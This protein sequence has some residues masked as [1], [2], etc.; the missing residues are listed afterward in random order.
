MASRDVGKVMVDIEARLDN[1]ERGMKKAEGTVKKSVDKMDKEAEKFGSGFSKS[2]DRIIKAFGILGAVEGGL[3]LATAATNLWDAALGDAA[4][5]A[6]K[7]QKALDA[8]YESITQLPFG[9]GPAVQ[10]FDALLRKVTGIGAEIDRLNSI[11]SGLDSINAVSQAAFEQRK[12]LLEQEKTL[13][14]T[15]PLERI[16]AEA[17]AQ[18]RQIEIE[19]EATLK[20]LR[21]TGQDPRTAENSL[22]QRREIQFRLIEAEKERRLREVIE[23]DL[24]ELG[25]ERIRRQE[26]AREAS[27]ELLIKELEAEGK[28]LDA[29]LEQIKQ[30]Y[31]KR[32]SLAKGAEE[33]YLLERLRA[34][35][36]AEAKKQTIITDAA[37]ETGGGAAFESFQTAIGALRSP[38]ITE[39]GRYQQQ[40]ADNTEQIK[41]NTK[42]SASLLE[43]VERKITQGSGIVLFA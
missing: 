36:I 35:E 4:G 22:R 31:D 12:K 20:R 5:N 6:E 13:G 8:A 27:N 33:R 26:Q 39:G 14:I 24:I 23:K 41:E 7:T 38:I 3:K 17:E 11:T 40:T 16:R 21:A 19:D 28:V 10:A 43:S 32:L 34:L 37:G 1:L 2:A 25:Q 18:K 30:F 15:D 9:I 29:R 42:K